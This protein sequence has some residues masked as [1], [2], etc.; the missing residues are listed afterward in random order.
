MILMGIFDRLRISPTVVPGRR[1]F[2]IQSG[3]G[4]AGVALSPVLNLVPDVQVVQSSASNAVAGIFKQTMSRTGLSLK[5]L[6]KANGSFWDA[7]SSFFGKWADIVSQNPQIGEEAALQIM[8]KEAGAALSM[9]RRMSPYREASR[10]QSL[11]YDE[12]LKALRAKSEST[13]KLRLRNRD[14]TLALKEKNV[15]ELEYIRT[16]ELYESWIREG[17]PFNRVPGTKEEINKALSKMIDELKLKLAEIQA[18]RDEERELKLTIEKERA[19]ISEL[20]QRLVKVAN[21]LQRI[22]SD[23]AVAL[24]AYKTN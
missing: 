17:I 14:L 21:K 3:T 11:N 12:G 7:Y 6:A 18:I 24:Q 10:A 22:E 23:R 4:I 1:N 20:Q 16:I 2:L 19:E 5:Q 8:G 9:F 13:L 15:Q